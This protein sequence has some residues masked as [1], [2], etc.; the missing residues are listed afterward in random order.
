MLFLYRCC[1]ASNIVDTKIGKN[2]Y[3]KQQEEITCSPFEGVKSEVLNIGECSDGSFQE[4][5]LDSNLF[6][7]NPSSNQ[8]EIQNQCDKEEPPVILRDTDENFCVWM[9]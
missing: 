4:I 8:V 3:G 1:S 6:S 7:I 2:A 9:N 5:I